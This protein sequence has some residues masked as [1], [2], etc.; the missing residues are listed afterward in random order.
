MTMIAGDKLAAAR[1]QAG[2]PPE[3]SLELLVALSRDADEQVRTEAR[4]TLASWSADTLTP[5]LTRRS[6]TTD[7]LEYFLALENVRSE[8]L[9]AILSN[10]N[11][12]QQAVGELAAIA[13]LDTVRVMLDNIDLL[14]TNALVAL[15]SNTA[16][17]KLNESRLAAKAEGFV[18]EPS[19]LELLIAEAQLE[20][21][22]LAI[23]PL[24]E[25]EIQ[26]LDQEIAAA[27]A[28]GDEE[29][30]TQSVYAKISRMNISQKVQLAVKGNKDERGILIRDPSKLIA[31]AVLGSPKVTDQEIETF[32]N[33]KSVSD[34]VMRLISLNRKFMKSYGVV[35]NLAFNPRTPLDIG[36]P[37]LNRLL[38]QDQRA[39]SVDKNVSE[40]MRKMALKVVKQKE[41]KA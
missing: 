12:P 29:K 5:L 4:H 13:D 17:L 39:L 23:K 35:H 22:R 8:L 33:L 27:E 34:E 10:R 40:V 18:F 20:E 30:K 41:K 38:P 3:A 7:V 6:T 36:L 16:Y 28:T 1:G 37:L 26:K 24:A 9:P 19:F 25:E 31:R 15:K 21:E 32:A 2:L 11:T 14:R